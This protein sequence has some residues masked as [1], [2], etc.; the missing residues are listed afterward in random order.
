MTLIK[1]NI[2]KLLQSCQMGLQIDDLIIKYNLKKIKVI[3]NH[4]Q[5]KKSYLIKY[6]LFQSLLVRFQAENA[7]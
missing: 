1:Q 2:K 5:T 7:L 3:G 6:V 4:W